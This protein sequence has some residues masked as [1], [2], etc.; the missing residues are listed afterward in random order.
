MECTASPGKPFRAELR[1]A[2]PGAAGAPPGCATVGG[3][4]R[5]GSADPEFGP[6]AA[7]V[8]GLVLGRPKLV[9]DADR[10]LVMVIRPVCR[11]LDRAC[12]YPWNR[13][14][15]QRSPCQVIGLRE[16]QERDRCANQ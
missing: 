13:A 3:D 6:V 12:Q 9:G 14:A 1:A 16:G 10:L 4:F 7:I 2:F 11:D 8:V 5:W 15:A